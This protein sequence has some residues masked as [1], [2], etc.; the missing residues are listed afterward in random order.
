VKY[1]WLSFLCSCAWT[2]ASTKPNIVIITVDTLRADRLSC[3][4]YQRQTSPNIDALISRGVRFTQAWTVE[5]LTTPSLVSMLTSLYPHEHGAT[6]NGL[7]CYPD[8]P[9]VGKRLRGIGYYTSAFIGNWT[10]RDGISGLAEHFDEYH[11]ILDRKRWFGM[12]L[13]ESTAE[14][15]T[16][17]AQAWLRKRGKQ[18]PFFLWVHYA[19]PHAPY[20]AH[21]KYAKQLDL[22]YTKDLPKSDRYDMEIAFTDHY[23]GQLLASIDAVSSREETLIFFTADHGESLGEHGYWGHGRNLHEP[24]L[25]IPMAAVWEG[26]IPPGKIDDPALISDIGTTIMGFHKVPPPPRS[27]GYDWSGPLTGEAPPAPQRV[28]YFQ[29]HKGAVQTKK[30]TRNGRRRGLLAVGVMHGGIKEI[31]R[32]KNHQYQIFD[33]AVDSGESRNLATVDTPLSEALK[34]WALDVE[35]GLNKATDGTDMLDERDVE[36]LRSLGYIE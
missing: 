6:R 8:L 31:F 13:S 17:A 1:L 16:E 9:S 21:K 11:E 14:H 26:R 25:R 30:G 10:L 27:H 36:M 35:N 33:L 22:A 2:F 20:L 5:P 3:Y 7:R 19:D 15:L 28:L 23:I 29:A 12:F 32:V 18:R 34:R 4:G 24:N